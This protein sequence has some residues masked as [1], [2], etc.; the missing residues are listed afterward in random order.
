MTKL[1]LVEIDRPQA[2]GDKL[3][4]VKVPLPWF[5]E[6]VTL[7]KSLYPLAPKEDISASLPRHSW[8]SIYQKS[9]HLHIKRLF[10]GESPF[11]GEKRPELTGSNNGMWQRQHTKETQEKMRRAWKYDSHFTPEARRKMSDSRMGERNP[12]YG[13]HWS[14]EERRLLRAKLKGRHLSPK[15]E[16]QKGQR[17]SQRTEFKNGHL[18]WNTGNHLPEKLKIRLS[19][20]NK[21]KHSSI[22][23]RQKSSESHRKLWGNPVFVAEQMQARHIRPTKPEKQIEAILNK[24]F[25]QFKYNGDGRLGIALGGLTPDFVNINGKKQVIEVFGDYYHSPDFLG[26]R[27]R[28]SELGKI[29]I[30]KSVGWD[31]LVIWEHELKE[32]QKVIDSISHFLG[33]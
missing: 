15:T 17:I 18:P 2:L 9:S 26:D 3:A 32:E 19:N 20:A 21:G 25:P 5:Q 31:C 12:F 13:N 11:K 4:E 14:D 16:I 30:Y 23:A 10:R 6:E 28:G 7:L 8:N 24:H 27:W 33:V 1:Q 22:K 29:M